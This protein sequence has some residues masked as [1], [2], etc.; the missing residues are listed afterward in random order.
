MNLNTLYNI[1]F[2]RNVD[3]TGVQTYEPVLKSRGAWH[4]YNILVKSKEFEDIVHKINSNVHHY[5]VCGADNINA[6][7]GVFPSVITIRG[8]SDFDSV[9]SIVTGSVPL[10]VVPEPRLRDHKPKVFKQHGKIAFL[11]S[12]FPRFFSENSTKHHRDNVVDTYASFWKVNDV[13]GTNYHNNEDFE[14]AED[15]NSRS[16][17]LTHDIEHYDVKRGVSLLRDEPNILPRV[18]SM[19]NGIRRSIGDYDGNH[20]L[21]VRSRSDVRIFDFLDAA[22]G[23]LH[24]DDVNIGPLSDDVVYIPKAN[25]KWGVDV[26]TDMIAMGNK[27][28]MCHFKNIIDFITARENTLDI[29][30]IPELILYEYFQTLGIRV[31]PINLRYKLMRVVDFGERGH[32]CV[33]LGRL[34]GTCKT[35]YVDNSTIVQIVNDNG[36]YFGH[37]CGILSFSYTHNHGDD[38]F[39][40]HKNRIYTTNLDTIFPLHMKENHM[41]YLSNKSSTRFDMDGPRVPPYK[42]SK[43]NLD[44]VVSRYNENLEWCKPYAEMCVVYNKGEPLKNNFGYKIR[45]LKNVGRESHTYLSH[46][47]YNWDSLNEYTMF[48][49]GGHIGHGQEKP[50]MFEGI[51]VDDYIN[52]ENDVVMFL[53]ACQ[54][55]KTHTHW[56]REGYQGEPEWYGKIV[57]KKKKGIEN[58]QRIGALMT[59]DG[60]WNSKNDTG[61]IRITPHGVLTYPDGTGGSLLSFHWCPAFK[62]SSFE[63]FWNDIFGPGTCPDFLY[64]TQGA[65]FKVHRDVIKKRPIEFYR[66]LLKY[67]S[68][69]VNPDEGYFCEMIW[70][71]VFVHFFGA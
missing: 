61:D 41:I 48:L 21:V 57:D 65:Q 59:P 36:Q 46:I 29:P 64:Y 4:V 11:L 25:Y 49:Q 63:A 23:H 31:V 18:K 17:V 69:S 47:V 37:N 51:D 35:E 24:V 53:S 70:Y 43:T 3:D 55:R 8:E 44:I 66:K 20:D 50:H 54:N 27:K 52:I 22:G 60:F 14:A 12:G 19:Y 30:R 40:I 5:N 56:L 38:K 9:G 67:V 7:V 45:H 10:Y 33:Y 34:Y 1:A 16:R 39:I 13:H 62:T 32:A 71:Y 58:R 15:T 42:V 26:I 68:H 6:H 28:V 2:C